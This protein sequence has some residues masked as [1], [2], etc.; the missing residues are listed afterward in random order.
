MSWHLACAQ[1]FETYFVISSCLDWLTV[2]KKNEAWTFNEMT[3]NFE[4]V[5]NDTRRS[6]IYSRVR[7][8]FIQEWWRGGK[9][10]TYA[11]RQIMPDFLIVQPLWEWMRVR[12]VKLWVAVAES[13]ALSGSTNTVAW[14]FVPLYFAITWFILRSLKFVSKKLRLKP[15]QIL[16]TWTCLQ[17]T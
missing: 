12:F 9:K 3:Y 13:G 15:M 11:H 4:L 6:N 17:A 14:M 10:R 7:W 16:K 8:G 2:W 5:L 1:Q